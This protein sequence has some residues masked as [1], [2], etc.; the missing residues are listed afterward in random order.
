MDGKAGI[1]IVSIMIVMKM[2]IFIIN[3]NVIL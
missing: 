2:V 1:L 3:N